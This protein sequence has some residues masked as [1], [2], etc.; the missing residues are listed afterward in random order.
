[1]SW[2]T[3]TVK[4]PA[5]TMRSPAATA[6]MGLLTGRNTRYS[7]RAA[8]TSSAMTRNRLAMPARNN[9]WCAMMSWAVRAA[10]PGVMSPWIAKL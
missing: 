7:P 6:E 10:L 8:T 1:M 4:I 5:Y 9:P 3:A 2:K